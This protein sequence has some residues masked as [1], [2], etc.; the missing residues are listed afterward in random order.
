MLFN[1]RKSLAQD[2]RLGTGHALRESRE[3]GAAVAG[4][5]KRGE[6]Q[7]GHVC[8]SGRCRAVPPCT[9]IPFPAREPLFRQP[10]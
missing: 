8:F 9:A 1:V 3:R 7:L 6:H 5:V 2:V 10:V 4:L